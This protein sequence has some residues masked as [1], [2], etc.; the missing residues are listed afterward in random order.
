MAA[1]LLPLLWLLDAD[2]L[3][4]LAAVLLV[5]GFAAATQDVAIDALCIATTTPAERG[6]YNGWMQVGVLLGRA[7]MG[8]GVL[9]LYGWLGDAGAVALLVTTIISSMLLLLAVRL[10]SSTHTLKPSSLASL[11][12]TYHSAFSHRSTWRGVAF[13]LL[14]GAA[15]KSFEAVFGIFL[16]DRGFSQQAIGLFTAGPMIGAIVVGSLLGGWLVDRIGCFR[17]VRSVLL[18]LAGLIALLAWL[19]MASERV[20]NVPLLGLIAAIGAGIG[21]FT[22]ASYAMYMNLTQPSIAATQFSTFMGAI[23]GCESWSV[24]VLGMLIAGWGYGPGFLVMCG[25]SL[26]ALPLLKQISTVSRHECESSESAAVANH[27]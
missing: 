21:V 8:G 2:D 5:H 11:R 17:F 13:A 23:N 7:A 3:G 4:P 15:F 16:V 12:R 18:I 20:H 9:A 26:L 14:A 1:T 27:D 19:D 10:P 6:A 25:L 22:A 24:Y